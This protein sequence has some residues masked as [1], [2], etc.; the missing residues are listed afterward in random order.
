MNF[1]ANILSGMITVVA[2]IGFS[3][4][5]QAHTGDGP[6]NGWL[7]GFLHPLSGLDH[8]LAMIAVGMWSMQLSKH[9]DKHVVWLMPVIFV[10]TM[11]LGGL[12]GFMTLPLGFAEHGIALSLLVTGLLI[13]LTMHLS[14]PASALLIGVF[15][16]CHGYAHGNEMP[17]DVVM[18]EYAAGFMLATALLHVI[19]IGLAFLMYRI[20]RDQ[21]LRYAG[22]AVALSGAVMLVGNVG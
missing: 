14:F 9:L 10:M 8:L 3:A 11:G 21:W 16:V 2:L 12:L 18:L 1:L 17:D 19:G 20:K 7:H 22:L 15:A 13:A 4:T 6:H 5:A